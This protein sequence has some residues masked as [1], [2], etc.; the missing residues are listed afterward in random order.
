MAIKFEDDGEAPTPRKGDV[1][2]GPDASLWQMDAVMDFRPGNDY[3]YREGYRRAGRILTEYVAEHRGE[4]DVLVFPICH[5][6]RH[7]VELSLKRLIRVGCSL[8]NR[9]LTERES[10]LCNGIHNL[11]ALWNAFVAIGDELKTEEGIDPPPDEDMEGIEDYID[12]L[13]AVD[14][15]SFSFRYPLTKTGEVSIQGIT[16]INLGRF[17]ER[18][19]GLCNYLEGFEAYYDHLKEVQADMMSDYAPDYDA[20]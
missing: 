10:S 4:Q 7:F 11:R 13:H 15:G 18:M 2:F 12:Q 8:I 3:P 20:Y 17:C 9:E 5:A 19:E 6:Y 14:A 16:R 1:L